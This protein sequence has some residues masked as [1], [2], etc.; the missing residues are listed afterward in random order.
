MYD[1]D[2]VSAHSIRNNIQTDH[3]SKNARVAKQVGMLGQIKVDA[4]FAPFLVTDHAI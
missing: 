3:L 4:E 1:L 2:I